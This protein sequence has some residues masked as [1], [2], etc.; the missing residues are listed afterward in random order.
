MSELPVL[1]V[2]RF[3]REAGAVRVS[4]RAGKALTK[5]LEERAIKIAEKAL[6]LAKYAGRKRITAEDIRLALELV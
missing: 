5:L 6:F 1:E 4:E 2:E 3:L